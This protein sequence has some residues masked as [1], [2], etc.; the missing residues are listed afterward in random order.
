MLT[1]H[2]HITKP[3]HTHTHITKHTYIH[4]QVFI[5]LFFF[6]LYPITAAVS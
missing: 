4:T 5:Y 6:L 2:P 1:K 3:I